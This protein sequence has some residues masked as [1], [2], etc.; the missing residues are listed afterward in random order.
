VS[1]SSSKYDSGAVVSPWWTGRREERSV[2]MLRSEC[3]DA[4]EHF[5]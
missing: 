3:E 5:K 2:Y 4:E 1:R